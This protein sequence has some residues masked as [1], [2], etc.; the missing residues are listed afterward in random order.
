MVHG[1]G[2][3]DRNENVNGCRIDI[4]NT[5]AHHLAGIGIA[6]LR[7]DKRGCGESSGDYYSAGY[8][9]LVE[10]A[11]KCFDALGEYGSCARDQLFILGHSEGCL[12][13]SQV[14]VLR[15][16]VAGLI[17]LAPYVEQPRVL[18][19]KQ[20]QLFQKELDT[21]PGIRGNLGR[22]I[23]KVIGGPI[24]NQ[25]QLIERLGRT[26]AD[27]IRF[28][29]Q[30]IPAK[31]MREL[32]TIDPANIYSQIACPMLVIGGA[33]DLQCDPSDIAQIATLAQGTVET[34][35]VDNLTHYLR[36]DYEEASIRNY[37]SLL[38][39]N[40]E[41]FVLELIENWFRKYVDPARLASHAMQPPGK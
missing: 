39:R 23:A 10:D 28:K 13:G 24:V 17:L 8:T 31:W 12:I 37:R 11:I 1:T 7:Y 6:S 33:K 20:A 38:K 35:V 36:Y 29:L 14:C 19:I 2:P 21:A 16:K 22:I 25:H 3:V 40:I 5:L 15:P 34:H 41:P 4:F 30:K 27:V 26:S 18:A 9:D 32:L